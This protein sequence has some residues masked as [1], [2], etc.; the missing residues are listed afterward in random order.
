ML[1]I[2]WGGRSGNGC[3]SSLLDNSMQAFMGCQLPASAESLPFIG[4][5][6]RQ[7]W[8]VIEVKIY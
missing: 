4:S 7:F 5:T 3:H 6:R 8:V 1:N 2:G